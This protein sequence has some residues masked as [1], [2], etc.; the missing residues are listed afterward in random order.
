MTLFPVFS[1]RIAIALENQGFDVIKTAPNDKFQGKIVYYFEETGE[2]RRA[3]K[4]LIR[5]TNDTKNTGCDNNEISQSITNKFNRLGE[6][7]T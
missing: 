4:A 7:K 6:D 1:R 5:L 2:L 3:A